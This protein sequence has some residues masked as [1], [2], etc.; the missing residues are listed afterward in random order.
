[1][2]GDEW[3][4]CP[5]IVNHTAPLDVAEAECVIV[6]VSRLALRH[7]GCDGKYRFAPIQHESK[8][9]VGTFY[10]RPAI[11]R[12]DSAGRADRP[13]AED[14][15]AAALDAGVVAAARLVSFENHLDIAASLRPRHFAAA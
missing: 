15:A 13:S 12:G 7:P 1:D 4:R 2:G 8:N 6:V 3:E 14:D 10:R 5:A 9:S 11:I